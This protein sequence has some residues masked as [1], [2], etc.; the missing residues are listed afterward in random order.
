[1]LP[2]IFNLLS[3]SFLGKKSTS[4]THATKPKAK[5]KPPPALAPSIGAYP[6]AVSA[7]HEQDFMSSTLGPMDN[8]IP[9][10]LP[11][12]VS[13]KRKPSPMYDSDPESSP[14][15]RPG[16]SSY[17]QKPTYGGL[18]SDGPMDESLLLSRDGHISSPNKC[19]R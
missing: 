19:I 11:K 1:M 17:R 6:P 7:E 9:D 8:I 4:K 18:S 3:H 2:L 10:G 15:P 16:Y 5:P 13:R 14:K 12:K